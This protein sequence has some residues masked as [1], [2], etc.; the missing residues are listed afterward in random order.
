VAWARVYLLCCRLVAGAMIVLRKSLATPFLL[1]GWMQTEDPE[2]TRSLL[3]EITLSY[4]ALGARWLRLWAGMIG[5]YIQTERQ[6][7]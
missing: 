3:P 4:Q 5:T 7:Q 6:G 1:C 2:P